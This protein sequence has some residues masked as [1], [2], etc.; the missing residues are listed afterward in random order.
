MEYTTLGSTG[1][2]VSRLCLGCM[3][4]GDPDWREWVKGEEFGHELVERARDLGINFFDTANMYSR[5]ESERILGDALE[6]HREESVVAT[7]VFFKMRDGDPNSGGL[8]RKTI[9]QE[10]DA[11]LDRLGMDTLD[12][13]QTHRWDYDTPI[14][15][16]L[17]AF[18]DA[19][20]SIENDTSEQQAQRGA[21]YQFEVVDRTNGTHLRHTNSSRSFVSGGS[22]PD[23]ANWV[24]TENVPRLRFYRMTVQPRYLYN[25][26]DDSVDT[27]MDNA[28]HVNI[29]GQDESGT[30]VTWNIHLYEDDDTGD[31]VVVGGEESDLLDTDTVSDLVTFDDN[32]QVAT[33]TD[34]ENVTIDIANGTVAGNPCPGLAFQDS[35]DSAL[36]VRYENADD[37]TMNN[38]RSG[39]TYELAIGTT[40]YESQYFYDSSGDQ[41]PYATHIIYAARIK[42]EYSRSDITHSRT[43]RGQPGDEGYVA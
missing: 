33:S 8:S 12:L 27:L 19:V 11:S 43:G 41:S 2:E 29:T 18:D 35:F 25:T 5:G 30:D 32:C 17:R 6:G 13:Y 37:D 9:E 36:S 1:I 14:E 24:L 38:S 34:S 10:L 31:V 26:T 42:S 3:S 21:S 7:K 40:D 39:G 23:E 22:S 28:F 16:T 15:Q 20:S 4:F